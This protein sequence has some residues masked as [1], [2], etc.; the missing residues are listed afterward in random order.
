MTPTAGQFIFWRVSD[1]Y[2]STASHQKKCDISIFLESIVFIICTI[3]TLTKLHYLRVYYNE[4]VKSSI[5]YT[6]AWNWDT[7]LYLYVQRSIKKYT[8]HNKLFAHDTARC[9]CVYIS[10]IR[11]YV[12]C[13]VLKQIAKPLKRLT[14]YAIFQ[15]GYIW[16]VIQHRRSNTS[17]QIYIQAQ[18]TDRI[19]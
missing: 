11:I 13:L 17:Q 5:W 6:K 4:S 15:H 2:E 19:T 1:Y 7:P 14:K 9:F 10:T 16:A 12:S 18:P 3:Q 8:I